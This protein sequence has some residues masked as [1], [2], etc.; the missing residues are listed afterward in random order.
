MPRFVLL[1]ISLLAGMGLFV[2]VVGAG[3][4]L[5]YVATGST[6]PQNP[7]A[8]LLGALLLVNAL[9]AVF[10]GLAT[11]KMTR[12]NS[13]YTV[14]LLALMMTMSSI[15]PLVRGSENAGEPQWYLLARCVLVFAGI[16]AGGALQRWGG[17]AAESA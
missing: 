7:S 16:L 2:V 10:A 5:A 3:T 9:A 13:L 6:S 17:R 8:A 15:V 1:I 14:L 4:V 11:S 12:Q